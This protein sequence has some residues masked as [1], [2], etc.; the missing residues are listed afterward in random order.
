MTKPL[1]PDA[2]VVVV[3]AGPAGATAAAVLAA[4]GYRVH[5]VGD[6]PGE[7]RPVSE[8]LPAGIHPLLEELGLRDRLTEIGAARSEHAVLDWGNGAE[9]WRSPVRGPE[10]YDHGYHVDTAEFAALLRERARERGAIVE[11]A[12]VLEPLV[13]DGVVTGVTVR[14]SNGRPRP[15]TARFTVDASA[16]RV[17]AG[18][19]GALRSDPTL[20][21][22]VRR[23]RARP[24]ESSAGPGVFHTEFSPETRTWRW[25]VPC[26]DHVETGRMWP[27]D[28]EPDPQAEVWTPRTAERLAGPGWL[29]VGDAAGTA[30]PLFLSPAAVSVLAAHAASDALHAVLAG[31]ADPARTVSGYES[32]YADTLAVTHRFAVF[33]L[34]A[35]RRGCSELELARGITELLGSREVGPALSRTRAALEGRGPLFD[36]ECPEGP[37]VAGVETLPWAARNH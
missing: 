29:A 1:E 26:R 6:A 19:F 3:G 30:D 2:D 35:A 32:A 25:V 13:V 18:H 23:D 5:V 36:C 14:A 31:I 9:P 33:C 15:I 28:E 16:E 7:R 21:F 20:R 17:V 11:S 12:P 4:R 8:A 10:P 24:E 34:D 27:T 37:L 22:L